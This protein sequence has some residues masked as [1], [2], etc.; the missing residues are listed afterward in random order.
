MH[1]YYNG[2]RLQELASLGSVMTVICTFFFFLFF[3]TLGVKG[4]G[5]GSDPQVQGW[6]WVLTPRCR[7]GVGVDPQVQSISYTAL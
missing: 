6:G 2:S 4:V 7:G 5:V 1:S 3:S